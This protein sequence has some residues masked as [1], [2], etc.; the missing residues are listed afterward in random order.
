MAKQDSLKPV[1]VLIPC[2]SHSTAEICPL[3]KL[4]SDGVWL[5]GHPC[6]LPRHSFWTQRDIQKDPASRVYPKGQCI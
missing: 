3:K 2:C 6:L 5:S 4:A 1:P